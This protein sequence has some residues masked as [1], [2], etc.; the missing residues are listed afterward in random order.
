MDMKELLAIVEAALHEQDVCPQCGDP[1]CTC[2]PG[3][4]DCEPVSEATIS[5]SDSAQ[6]SYSFN[7]TKTMG[8]GNN[9]NI[10]ATAKSMDEL[11]QMLQMAG[12]DPSVADKYAEPEIDMP[13]G[14]DDAA[15]EV[16]QPGPSTLNYRYET[17]KEKLIDIIKQRLQQKLS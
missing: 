12:I 11:H 13:C 8:D 9:I 2:P 15:P 4:C 6:T 16:E 14:C 7:Q 17:D 5:E 1:D 3:E 10:N